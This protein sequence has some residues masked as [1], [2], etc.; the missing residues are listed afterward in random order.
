MDGCFFS[1]VSSNEEVLRTLQIIKSSIQAHK[2]NSL[3]DIRHLST[4]SF[5]LV[6]DLIR[7]AFYISDGILYSS[8]KKLLQPQNFSRTSWIIYSA[9]TE[10]WSGRS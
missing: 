10:H 3:S 4:V 1:V 5:P 9:H 6:C 2:S 7:D 8:F